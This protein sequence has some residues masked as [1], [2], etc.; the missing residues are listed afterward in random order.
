MA[1]PRRIRISL[2]LRLLFFA[3][4][5]VASTASAANSKALLHN[6]RTPKM[7]M[8]YGQ[9]GKGTSKKP[10]ADDVPWGGGYV[11]PILSNHP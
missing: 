9:V 7:A 2:L 3:L 8:E 4:L 10:T 1:S 11:P 5:L 6:P